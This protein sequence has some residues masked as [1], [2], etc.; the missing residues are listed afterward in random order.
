M[1]DI[2]LRKSWKNLYK[3]GF[4]LIEILV[5]ISI[6]S[7]ISTVGFVQFSA[8]Q[9][10]AR[11]VRRKNDLNQFQTALQL[12]KQANGKYPFA[13]NPN[14]PS[15]MNHW[16]SSAYGWGV[17][18][19]PGVQTINDLVPNY[20]P[21]LPDDPVNNCPPIW[22]QAFYTDQTCYG[23]DYW[24]G[25]A[26]SYNFS[27]PCPNGLGVLY[28]LITKL[29][30]DADK[31]TIGNGGNRTFCGRDIEDLIYKQLSPNDYVIVEY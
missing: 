14:D 21:K 26:A 6:I 20:M 16:A 9:K 29:E 25:N 5:A 27:P 3:K 10:I 24:S 8:S 23:Y 18:Y 11:D 22:N 28:I 2:G 12:Y 7:I 1:P 15:N 13:S 4:T 17:E 31:E 30:N 19:Q